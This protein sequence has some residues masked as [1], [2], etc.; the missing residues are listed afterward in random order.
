MDQLFGPPPAPTGA[1][2]SSIDVAT[3]G[4][5]TGIPMT[6]ENMRALQVEVIKLEALER[7]YDQAE[8]LGHTSPPLPSP[9]NPLDSIRDHEAPK[10]PQAKKQT[11]G[12][13]VLAKYAPVRR[14][15]APIGVQRYDGFDAVE[16][17]F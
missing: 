12:E 5:S 3:E 15:E 2:A 8:A 4:A 1:T 14:P 9:P 16:E 7:A 13:S 11:T 17:E 10:V 6:L